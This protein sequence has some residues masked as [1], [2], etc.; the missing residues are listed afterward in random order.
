MARITA[1]WACILAFPLV[2]YFSHLLTVKGAPAAVQHSPNRLEGRAPT[3]GTVA[4]NDTDLPSPAEF[5]PVNSDGKAAP[6]AIKEAH[7]NGAVYYLVCGGSTSLTL[8]DD[9][10][11]IGWGQSAQRRSYSANTAMESGDDQR[12][13]NPLFDETSSGAS[14]AQ[15]TMYPSTIPGAGSS[16]TIAAATPSEQLS[17]LQSA[18]RTAS[19]VAG[20][21]RD[22]GDSGCSY[23]ICSGTSCDPITA[24][25][26]SSSS[27][28]ATWEP[29]CEMTENTAGVGACVCT[30]GMTIS[31]SSGQ[32]P[33][34]VLPSQAFTTT[35]APS[36]GIEYPFTGTDISGD[37]IECRSEGVNDFGGITTEPV[38]YCLGSSAILSLAT[39][40]GSATLEI[41]SSSVNV[42]QLT[43]ME[44]YTSVSD[45]LSDLCLRTPGATACDMGPSATATIPG[46]QYID[47][48]QD[49]MD[50]GELLVSIE[51]SL[52]YTDNLANKAIMMIS[53][54]MNASTTGNNCWTDTNEN[55]NPID[56]DPDPINTTV[57]N[58]AGLV[59]FQYFYE[60]TG[61][62]YIDALFDFQ[63]MKG[64]GQFACENFINV[65]QMIG[66]TLAPEYR[67]GE[68]E[69]GFA[70]KATCESF[71]EGENDN[72]NSTST[73][74][75]LGIFGITSY[76]P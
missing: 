30:N 39:H 29:P 33:W 16:R 66:N 5:F 28:P 40:S 57:C 62:E 56:Y 36:S 54:A 20:F 21:R 18:R 1:L 26:S 7:D 48:N 8:G 24:V 51:D 25:T 44:L 58:A 64:Q 13:D 12:E 14:T 41:G 15:E 27:L 22:S 59:A 69:A 53:S 6:V 73:S 10:S 67:I 65:M 4:S 50:N 42:G 37:I 34:T 3:N 32:C 46:V 17:T 11:A 9:I 68:D 35:S 72:A 2:T 52:F 49:L 43:D 55:V 47:E 38:T 71:M 23:I 60:P 70:F 45:A 76:I 75:G 61:F 31:P 19:P 74:E 63:I